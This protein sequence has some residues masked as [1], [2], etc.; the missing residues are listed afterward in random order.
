MSQF[1]SHQPHVG[2]N[3]HVHHQPAKTKVVDEPRAVTKRELPDQR[4][5]RI[6]QW[7][8][9]SA[10]KDAA[11]GA[12]AARIVAEQDP[13][14]ALA[15]HALARVIESLWR[16]QPFMT[17]DDE[18]DSATQRSRAQIE[19]NLGR[20]EASCIRAAR[21]I[22]LQERAQQRAEKPAPSRDDALQKKPRAERTNRAGASKAPSPSRPGPGPLPGYEQPPGV[23]DDQPIQWREYIHINA[24]VD[25]RW[26]VFKGTSLTADSIA[27]ALLDGYSEA[28]ILEQYPFLNSTQIRAARACDAEGQCGP[29]EP[30][31][32]P[33]PSAR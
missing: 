27:S 10:R 9:E 17:S 30:P 2:S 8:P 4:V 1:S 24:S 29:I 22:E 26:P 15:E 16:L 21:L 32:S 3:G 28:A 20:A 25:P 31:D 5:T 18:P 12:L 6:L 14:T 13:A 19:Q 7:L 33:A 23:A 11:F